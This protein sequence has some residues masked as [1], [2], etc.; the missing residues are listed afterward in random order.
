M[1]TLFQ[2]VNDKQTEKLSDDASKV[3][4]ITIVLHFEIQFKLVIFLGKFLG[5]R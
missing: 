5:P 1:M 2:E 3:D 4:T